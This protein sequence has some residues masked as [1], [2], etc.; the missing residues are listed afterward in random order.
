MGGPLP[1]PTR[2][3][4]LRPSPWGFPGPSFL[5]EAL[6]SEVREGILFCS[7]GCWQ[8]H[9]GRARAIPGKSPGAW[10]GHHPVVSSKEGHSGIG[11]KGL[12]PA[13]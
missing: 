12:A 5:P 1:R 11:S 4:L 9:R 6:P 8:E 3:A 7:E 13:V 10:V 2:S